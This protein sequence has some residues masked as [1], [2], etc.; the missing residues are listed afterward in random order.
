MCTFLWTFICCG[1]EWIITGPG[2]TTT[3]A[4]PTIAADGKAKTGGA[5]ITGAGAIKTGA[6]IPTPTPR[7]TNKFV[8]AFNVVGRTKT[9]MNT[10][11]II[12]FFIF[13]SPQSFNLLIQKQN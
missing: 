5:T 4:G 13:S 8:S 7:L 10:K 11:V 9:T 1:P 6:G 12:S 2:Y 3:G